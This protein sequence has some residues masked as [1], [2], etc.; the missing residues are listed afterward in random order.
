MGHT[1]RRSATVPRGRQSPDLLICHRCRARKSGTTNVLIGIPASCRDYK[2]SAGIGRA[3]PPGDSRGREAIVPRPR[4][5]RDNR[6]R[7]GRGGGG[8]RRD[9]LQ[10]LWEHCHRGADR[11]VAPLGSIL[12]VSSGRILDRF[13]DPLIACTDAGSALPGPRQGTNQKGACPSSSFAPR[14]LDSDPRDLRIMINLGVGSNRFR[15]RTPRLRRGSLSLGL[16]AGL[17]AW[18]RRAS[19][20]G[21][22][23]HF[24]SEPRHPHPDISARCL[25]AWG[26]A[27][28]ASGVRHQPACRSRLPLMES[29]QGMNGVGT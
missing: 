9:R 29:D 3:D 18:A 27:A 23:D 25:D 24:D 1:T 4:V 5:C 13:G 19:S 21:G 15:M 12:S 28:R 7:R 17:M 11:R 14:T 16:T 2:C 20:S 26:L 10:G 6:R 22:S 8:L